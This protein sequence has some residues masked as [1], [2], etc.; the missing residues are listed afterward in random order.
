MSLVAK[1]NLSWSQLRDS[2]GLPE[3]TFPTD[4]L[5]EGFFHSTD[6]SIT[7]GHPVIE[8]A[9]IVSCHFCRRRVLQASFPQHMASCTQQPHAEEAAGPSVQVTQPKSNSAGTKASRKRK[10]PP[11][12]TAS[13]APQAVV[14][15][16]VEEVVEKAEEIPFEKPIERPFK[17]PKPI[18][19]PINK[20]PID[21][22]K[23]CGVRIDLGTLCQRSITCK[24]HSVGLKR[25][26]QG[27]SQLYD[28][29]V[30]EHRRPAKDSR[31]S[32]PNVRA[33]TAGASGY[34]SGSGGGAGSSS[35]MGG[36]SG[37]GGSGAGGGSSEKFMT[38]DEEADL[39]FGAIRLHK[40]TPICCDPSPSPI[41]I[42]WTFRQR[43]ALELAF[44]GRSLD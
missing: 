18:P 5:D 23:H 33:G 39:V 10:Q 32:T 44:D 35:G 9:I 16:V 8:P 34:G 24:I 4:P 40:P 2:I 42:M 37:M 17:T 14:P 30:A 43:S 25:Q 36:A 41:N 27:R 12:S 7:I 28:T 19:R 15:S 21:L 22:D 38:K 1:P 29:L 3:V 31:A 20:G 11:A 13:P 26:V 6:G